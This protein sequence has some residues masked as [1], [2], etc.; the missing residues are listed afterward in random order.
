[1]ADKEKQPKE[2]E[3]KELTGKEKSDLYENGKHRRYNLLFAVNGGAFAVA[4]IMTVIKPDGDIQNIVLGSLSLEELSL[5]MTIF[6]LIM[7]ADIF[8]FGF[9][10]KETNKEWYKPP[11]GLPGI[12]VLVSICLL[13]CAGWLRVGGRL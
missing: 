13:I 11:F 10:S 2:C 9:N 1:M 7:G 5:G 8:V 4:K 3:N 6:T 12:L